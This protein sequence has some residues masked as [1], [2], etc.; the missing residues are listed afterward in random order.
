MAK[1]VRINVRVKRACCLALFDGF[2]GDESC[3]R[4][5]YNECCE[6]LHPE[7]YEI[8]QKKL[9]K[10]LIEAHPG[11]FEVTGFYDNKTGEKLNIMM[12]DLA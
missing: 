8:R 10:E 4:C 12:G 9:T 2:V 7:V 6:S 5:E 3:K 11:I 1:T